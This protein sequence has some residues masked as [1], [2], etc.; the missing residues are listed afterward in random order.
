MLNN[1]FP[2]EHKHLWTEYGT[3]PAFS[4]EEQMFSA[5]D[6]KFTVETDSTLD[7][8]LGYISSWSAFIKLRDIEGE[9]AASRFI[10]ESKQKLTDVMGIPD[11]RVVLRRRYKYF[12]RMWRNPAA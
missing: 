11:E 7:D 10:S 8:F 12:L 2:E 5:R 1:Y 9:A 4:P 3:L 6:E